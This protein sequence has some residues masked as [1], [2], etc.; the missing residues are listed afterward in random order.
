[1]RF[2][3]IPAEEKKTY[4]ERMRSVLA[5]LVFMFYLTCE[6]NSFKCFLFNVVVM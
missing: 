3:F 4:E 5:V 2:W 1:M 6:I